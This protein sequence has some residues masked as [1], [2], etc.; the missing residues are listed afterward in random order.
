[1]P[2]SLPEPLSS[3][4]WVRPH[5]DALDLD[6]TPGRYWRAPDALIVA[7]AVEANGADALWRRR[8]CLLLAASAAALPYALWRDD[9]RYWLWRSYP[10]AIDADA[11]GA[12]LEEQLALARGLARACLETAALPARQAARLA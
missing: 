7:C 10:A 9:E 11:L 8:A 2:P 12:G 6:G 4:A 1:M 5:G 3:L